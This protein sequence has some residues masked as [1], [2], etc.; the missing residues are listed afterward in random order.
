MKTF[1]LR[2]RD[3]VLSGDQF[4]L[5]GGAARLQ[6][7]LGLAMSD[8]YGAD[9]FH[10]DWGSTLHQYVGVNNSP[11]TTELIKAE[12][13]RIIRYLL[14]VQNTMMTDRSVL[15]LKPTITAAEIVADISSVQVDQREDSLSVKVSVR[16]AS[17]QQV[18]VLAT[19]GRTA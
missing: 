19:T 2:N 7:Q 12:V 8:P 13:N 11:A 15:A 5:V 14:S 4:A 17:Q 10:P 16:T 6:Q 9:R 3:L 1:A 18:D